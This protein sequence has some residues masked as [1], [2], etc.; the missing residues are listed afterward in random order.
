MSTHKITILY[1]RLSRDDELAG[2]S[3]SIINQRRLLT[4]YAD[5]NGF[6]PYES[7]AD[8]GYSGTNG[9]RPGWQ[10]VIARIE[11][12][13]VST[14]IVKDSSRMFRDYLRAGLYREMFREKGVRLIAVNDGVDT[15]RGE[16]DLIPFRELMAE[17]YARDTSKKIKSIL[18]TKGWA[19][20]PLS[21]LPPY[22]YLK[23]PDDKDR[24]VIDETTAEIVRW[25]FRLAVEGKDPYEIARVLHD[26]KVERHSYYLTQKGLGNHRLKCDTENYHLSNSLSCG[27]IF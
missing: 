19:G 11:A 2:E 5:K 17:W 12:G 13:E 9:D 21:N 1:L 10:E 27:Y 4:E 23:D 20:R 25:I 14:L 6:I 3:N 26:A 7:I 16:D 24:W 18:G 8:D 15:A 22:G